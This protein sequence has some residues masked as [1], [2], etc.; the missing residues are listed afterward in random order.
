M[1]IY[2]RE[3]LYEEVW[4]EPV[5]AVAKKYGVTDVAIKKVCKKM[6]VPTP[7]RGYWQKV[8]AG[9]KIDKPKLPKNKGI[10]VERSQYAKGS[11]PCVQGKEIIKLTSMQ[12]QDYIQIKASEQLY[13]PHPMVDQAYKR[14]KNLWTKSREKDPVWHLNGDMLDIR[15]SKSSANRA[16]CIMNAVIKELISN[17]YSITGGIKWNK[18]THVTI[19]NESIGF[20]LHEHIKQVPH[21]KTEEEIRKEKKGHYVYIPTYD[22]LP[23]GT[24]ILTIEYYHH[25]PRKNWKDTAKRRL[26]ECLNDFIE[27]L[28][29]AAAHS[30]IETKKRLE[31]EIKRQE[32]AD[33]Q[34]LQAERRAKELEKFELLEK[35][36]N[37]WQRTQII[38]N[39]VDALEA[40]PATTVTEEEL[41]QRR[42]YIAW[43]R[44]KID[45]INPMVAKDDEILG[46][47]SKK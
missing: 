37:D 16:L 24:L 26:E 27:G 4:N 31:E 25:I 28:K 11:D 2:D 10:S 46:C 20:R 7:G 14:L 6:N 42:E 3:K 18:Y 41:R 5:I 29:M 1:D 43:A 34:S 9:A 15:V 38:K 47:R 40:L 36:A 19:E 35:D 32:E 39:Y 23:T 44:E 45:W 33:Y 8:K 22:Y 12:K 13:N 21:E 30:K 17:G